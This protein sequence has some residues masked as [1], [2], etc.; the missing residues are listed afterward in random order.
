MATIGYHL[1]D[2]NQDGVEE[3]VRNLIRNSGMEQNQEHRFHRVEAGTVMAQHFD[4]DLIVSHLA[5]SW[6]TFPFFVTLRALNPQARIV[7]V[8]LENPSHSNFGLNK[9]DNRSKSMLR[10]SYALFD[11]I[12]VENSGEA[13]RFKAAE[14]AS[15]KLIKVI[16]P[17]LES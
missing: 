14:L 2:P 12:I 13:H 15:D 11:R 17:P 1:I 10:C 7:H 16:S 6:R 3:R 8:E 4:T 9:V 5:I